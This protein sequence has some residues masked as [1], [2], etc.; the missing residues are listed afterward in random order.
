[1]SAINVIKAD[2]YV[3]FILKNMYTRFIKKTPQG[4]DKEFPW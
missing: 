2:H 1:M 4:C 3:Y